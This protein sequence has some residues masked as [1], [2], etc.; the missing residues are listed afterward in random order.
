LFK[1]IVAV[2]A[3]VFLFVS[4]VQADFAYKFD[5][6][7]SGTVQPSGGL[8]WLTATFENTGE[9]DQV[10]LT[11]TSSNLGGT[12]FV[13][14]WFFNYN[15]QGPS[16]L[17]ITQGEGTAPLAINPFATLGRYK[18]DGT[19]GWFDLTFAF[20]TEGADRFTNGESAVFTITGTGLTADM[21]RAQSWDSKT[22]GERSVLY[23][24]A[25]IQS[26]GS[27]SAWVTT[28]TSTTNTPIPAAA[29]LL[30]SGLLGLVAIRR[31]MK[32]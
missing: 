24:A 2:V 27:E 13:S 6:V 20:P 30:G 32:K 11:L 19:G 8:P 23:A 29:W 12:E 31:R 16:T 10:T 28:G 5:T 1:T 9:K 18:A 17:A 22:G 14:N 3:L 25:H 21:F 15:Y 4:P 7:F 26:I